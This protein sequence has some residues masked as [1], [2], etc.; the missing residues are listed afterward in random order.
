MRKI[1][2]IMV[3][4]QRKPKTVWLKTT[5]ESFNK[6]VS[7]GAPFPC[8]AKFECVENNIYLLYAAESRPLEFTANRVNGYKLISGIF[9]VIASDECGH[10][11]SLTNDEIKIYEAR[12]EEPAKIAT[13]EEIFLCLQDVI[14]DIQK[15]HFN[16]L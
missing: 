2:A 3:R 6:A 7:Q 10:P 1:R 13:D 5:M 14:A 15:L 12:Y 4:P 16:E 8:H 9:Y 11:I